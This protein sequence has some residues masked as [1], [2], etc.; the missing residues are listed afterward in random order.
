MR[1][2]VLTR[3]D[4]MPRDKFLAFFSELIDYLKQNLFQ[5]PRFPDGPN[6]EQLLI[7]PENYLKIM[8][9]CGD[10]KFEWAMY[11]KRFCEMR[12]FLAGSAG[13]DRGTPGLLHFLRLS[14]IGMG[15]HRVREINES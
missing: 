7:C 2:G 5:V 8:K 10:R 14:Y 4:L 1:N 6:E 12:I 13:Y 9:G 3:W 15:R 11:S